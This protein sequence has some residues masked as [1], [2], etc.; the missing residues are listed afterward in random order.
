MLASLSPLVEPSDTDN[1]VIADVLRQPLVH[2]NQLEKW[3]A[4]NAELF[5]VDGLVPRIQKV[6][7]DDSPRECGMAEKLQE[8]CCSPRPVGVLSLGLGYVS[9]VF[10]Q[11]LHEANHGVRGGDVSRSQRMRLSFLGAFISKATEL[12]THN[13]GHAQILHGRCGPTSSF[14]YIPRW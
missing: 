1:P 10:R 7:N 6:I 12:A 9:I 8:G 11:R 13:T 3:N 2:G 5:D 14:L 4:R